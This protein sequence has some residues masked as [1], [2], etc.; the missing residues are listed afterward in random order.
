MTEHA[1]RIYCM[2]KIFLLCLATVATTYANATSITQTPH[3]QMLLELSSNQLFKWQ[4]NG[5]YQVAQQKEVERRQQ[6]IFDRE[7]TRQNQLLAR[8]ADRQKR[9]LSRKAVRDQQ[10]ALRHAAVQKLAEERQQKRALANEAAQKR[11]EERERQR[12]QWLNKAAEQQ[13][14][15]VEEQQQKQTIA[16]E[17]AKKRAEE[18]AWQEAERLQQAAEQQRQQLIAREAAQQE[19]VQKERLFQEQQRQ[20]KLEQQEAF[21]RQHH[22]NLIILMLLL[23]FPIVLALFIK[24]FKWQKSVVASDKI[25]AWLESS[26]IKAQNKSGLFTDI[27]QRPILWC[28][29]KLFAITSSI[30]DEFLKAGVRLA[31]CLYLIGGVLFLV[32]VITMIVLSIIAVFLMLALLSAI[33]NNTDQSSDTHSSDPEP[34]R[35]QFP[36]SEGESRQIEGIL[37]PYT[38]IRNADGDVIAKSRQIEGILGPY[39]ETRNADGDVIAES[40][41]I[42]GILGPYT[43]TRNVDG[44]VIAES[45]QIEGI[46]GPYTETRNPDG[47]V[48]AESRQIEGILGPYTE[49]KKTE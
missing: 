41:Q 28:S 7:A 13:R 4:A 29:V 49:H 34:E 38:E 32:Y 46:L 48:I 10:Q 23:A 6:Q 8:E 20:R 14:Q 40:R 2:L 22:M 5:D 11:A 33:L 18:R 21:E 19:Q 35:F 31:A 26:I 43:E 45:R 9:I 36:V 44:D 12:V 3:R 17:A 47:E 16:H 39:T 1:Q 37:G 15:L 42:E 30:R 24:L 27:V 25:G